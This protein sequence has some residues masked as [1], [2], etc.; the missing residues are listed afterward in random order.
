MAIVRIPDQN[1]ICTTRK[2][3]T[4]HLAT[5]ES[6]TNAGNR[7][8]LSSTMPAPEEVLAAYSAEIEKLKGT[9][10]MSRRM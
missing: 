10:V 7:H 9:A 6:S 3:V 1:R 2:A 4:A 5:S 8:M